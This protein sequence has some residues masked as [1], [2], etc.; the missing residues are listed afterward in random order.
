MSSSTDSAA[1]RE[2]TPPTR[3]RARQR[4]D[5]KPRHPEAAATLAA[6]GGSGGGGRGGSGGN[7][8][9]TAAAPGGDG[10]QRP[11]AP[12]DREAVLR[13]TAS[14]LDRNGFE[15]TTIRSIAKELRCAVGSIYRH[16][17][18]KNQLLDEVVQGRFTEIA[19]AA[20]AGH[21]PEATTRAFLSAA[22][23]RP[24]Q[25]RLMFWLSALGRGS[26]EPA[27][28]PSV[29]RRLVAA[30]SQDDQLGSVSEAHKL[31]ARLHGELMLG[32]HDPLAAEAEAALAAIRGEPA[33]RPEPTDA[34]EAAAA[35]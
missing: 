20:E 28:V 3:G 24:E 19:E 18:D 17:T 27:A 29:M 2:D 32:R 1:G 23:S 25:Y 22:A 8:V 14:V 26:N 15:K 13:A 9:A 16:F 30:W 5:P 10:P 7:A 31:W 4:V 12:L 33:P 34:A 6:V 21:A 11:A 35:E